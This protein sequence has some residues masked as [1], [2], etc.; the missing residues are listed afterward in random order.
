MKRKKKIS[1]APSPAIISKP[2]SFSPLD[3][4]AVAAAKSGDTMMAKRLKDGLEAKYRA[5]ANKAEARAKHEIAKQVGSGRHRCC[6]FIIGVLSFFVL[7]CD[8][9]VFFFRDNNGAFIV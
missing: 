5:K 9:F 2:S 4:A 1:Q 8:I 6:Y 3:K 7:F